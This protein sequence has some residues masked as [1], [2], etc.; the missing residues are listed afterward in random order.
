[1]RA[2]VARRL[3][4]PVVEA[5]N[6][7]G[8][9]SPGVAARARLE[10]GRRCFVKA[11]SAAQNPDSPDIH[12]REARVSAAL[13]AHLPVPHLL[14]VID[15][16]D[17]VVLVL[18][19]VDGRPPDVPWSPDQLGA[20]L[21]ALEALAR[22]TTPSRIPELET[23]AQRQAAAFD[24]FRRLAGGDPSVGGVERVDPW[25][26]RHLD[27]LAD[28]EAGWAAAATGDTLVH[29]DVRADNLLVRGDG[30]VVVVD[31]PHAS[32]GAPWLDVVCLLP[33]VGLDGGP[34]PMDVEAVLV[35]FAG[36]DPDAVDL[37]LVGLTG[38]FTLHGL[39][40][41]PPGLPTLRAFQ[42]AQGEV[43][44]DWLAHRLQLD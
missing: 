4:S 13:P 6:Q 20:T 15:D 23:F 24:G 11:V 3:G 42:R 30:S 29:G 34:S 22:A 16:G 17:W 37:V 8:G 33:S 14:E 10:D 41:D 38:Y 40:P 28:L 12:R 43:A 36:V 31:W 18:E 44:R 27:R 39:Q 21:A 5:V 32:V 7:A 19:E 25:T 1:V 35:P 26:R 9:F 2:E